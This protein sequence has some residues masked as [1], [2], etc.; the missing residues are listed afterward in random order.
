MDVPRF[1]ACAMGV[2]AKAL[3]VVNDTCEVAGQLTFEGITR[4]TG[5]QEGIATTHEK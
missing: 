4:A 3:L 1:K 2:D 5:C